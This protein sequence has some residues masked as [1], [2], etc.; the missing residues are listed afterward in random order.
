L[1]HQKGWVMDNPVVIVVVTVLAVIV[2]RLL[3]A[4]ALAGGDA[5][6][7]GLAI[8]A[9]WRL[10]RDPAFGEKVRPLLGPVEQKP[11]KAKPS[12]EPLRLLAVLQRDSRFLD[13]FMDDINAAADEQIVAFVK[14]MHP[15]CQTSLKDHLVLEPV[16]SQTEGDTV[17]VPPGFDPSAIRLLGNVTGQPPFRGTL[18]HRGWRVK[19]I[20]LAL[21]PAGQ[22]EFVVQPA[23]LYLP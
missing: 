7:L 2:L 9:S 18:Q 23:E 11:V 14:K 1:L 5:Q 21:P 17:E 16:M 15:E 20:K 3:V 19:E 10:L 8:R 4:L 13:F 6:R 12:G 22:D